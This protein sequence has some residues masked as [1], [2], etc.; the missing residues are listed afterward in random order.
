MVLGDPATGPMW[1]E[2]AVHLRGQVSSEGLLVEPCLHNPLPPKA[3]SHDGRPEVHESMHL[4]AE[5]KSVRIAKLTCDGI[6]SPVGVL[7]KDRSPEKPPE[8]KPV[9]G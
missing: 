2:V 3:L 6:E 8:V 1:E 7:K 9:G 5:G 4:V